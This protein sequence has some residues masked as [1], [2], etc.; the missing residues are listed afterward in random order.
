MKRGV[1]GLQMFLPMLW[2]P[3]RSALPKLLKVSQLGIL[4][5]QYLSEL[6][7]LFTLT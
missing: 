3:E 7:D 1:L 2:S 5:N 6:N 4:S